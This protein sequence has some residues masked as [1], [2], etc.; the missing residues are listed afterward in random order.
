MIKLTNARPT[1]TR[2]AR[3]SVK[4]AQH[5]LRRFGRDEDGALIIFALVL[6]FLMVMMGGISV[7]LMRHEAKR[8]TLQQ[9]LDRAVLA[10]ASLQQELDPE[11]VVRDYFAKAGMTQYL[12]GVTVDQGLNYRVVNADA[13][14]DTNPLFMHMAGIEE[15]NAVADSQAEQRISNVEISLVL[16]ISG[17]MSGSRINALRPA[18]RDFI[19]TVIGSSEPGRVTISLVP[20]QSQVILGDPLMSQFNLPS[21]RDHNSSFCFDLPS[22]AY[23]SISLSLVD[24]Q[25]Q[26]GHFDPDSGQTT[27]TPTASTYWCKN[28]PA[29]QITPLSADAVYLKNRVNAMVV[30]GWTAIDIGMKWGALLLDPDSQPIVSGLI[31]AGVV[32]ETF[33]GRPLDNLTENVLKVVVIMSDGENTNDYRMKPE[34][35]TGPSNIFKRTSNGALSLYRPERGTNAY[36]HLSAGRWYAAPDGGLAGTTRLS[37]QQLWKDYTVRWVSK[38][39]YSRAL[40]SNSDSSANAWFST[41]VQNDANYKDGRLDAVCDATKDAGIVVFAIG[42]EAP[43]GGRSVL[44]SCASESKG[45]HYFDANTVDIGS[46]FNAIANQISNLRL[47][48]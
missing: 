33:E 30:G 45:D 28:L 12:N 6:F 15:F 5:R 3:G 32:D 20:Y 10:A 27:Q 26:S 11:A 25:Q 43:P 31:G 13:T 17:S 4:I 41:F 7:D 23:N 16:D 37:Y 38:N 2:I 18:A 9:T 36:Y 48:Q 14:A 34:Y 21:P 8:T 24:E 35:T 46:A 47:T 42:F 40:N 1:L 19:D 44:E 22:A 29:N 39:I